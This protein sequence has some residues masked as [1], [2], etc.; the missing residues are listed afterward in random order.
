MNISE[1]I[2]Q[3]RESA[4]FTQEEIAEKLGVNQQTVSG[5]ENGESYPDVKSL[6]ILSEICCVTLEFLF[7]GD[8]KMINHIQE[9]ANTTKS[10]KQVR[11][12]I[13]AFAIFTLAQ[14]IG[15]V[16]SALT[17]GPLTP[18]EPG[19]ISPALAYGIPVAIGYFI[20]LTI[21]SIIGKRI[22]TFFLGV[23]I[24]LLGKTIIVQTLAGSITYYIGFPVLMAVF[25]PLI[26]ALIAT[27]SFRI[28]FNGLWAVALPRE[29][30]TEKQR[31]QAISVFRLLSKTAAI[32]A[33]IAFAVGMRNMIVNVDFSDVNFVGTFISNISVFSI[34]LYYAVMLIVA[35][36]EPAILILKRRASTYTED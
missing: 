9:S 16:T 33:T 12:G 30:I 19:L 27:G 5:W 22:N 6:Y 34:P 17:G 10:N 11:I 4:N 28:F 8:E 36:F 32:T 15:M 31:E 18:L 13:I 23:G 20:I 1:K 35:V 25:I 21:F 2:K 7:K 26:A 24:F 3:A 14:I 29:E